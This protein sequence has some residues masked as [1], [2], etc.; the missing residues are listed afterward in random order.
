M[1]KFLKNKKPGDDLLSH[2][3]SR[4]VSSAL[5]SLTSGFGMEPGVSSLLWSP[6]ILR[7]FIDV[8]LLDLSGVKLNKLYD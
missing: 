7:F 2:S 3:V 4:V 5:K 1:K 8:T 6:G